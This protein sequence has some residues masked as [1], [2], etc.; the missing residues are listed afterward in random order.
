[1]PPYPRYDPIASPPARLTAIILEP[2][3]AAESFAPVLDLLDRHPTW[4]FDI[5]LQA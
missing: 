1:M 4:T 5:E 2:G 3:R